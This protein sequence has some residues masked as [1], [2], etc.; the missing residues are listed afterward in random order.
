MHPI[1]P[2]IPQNGINPLAFPQNPNLGRH[3][4]TNISKGVKGIVET[5]KYEVGRLKSHWDEMGRKE[6]FYY[7]T[8]ALCAL[9]AILIILFLTNLF[10]LAAL[11]PAF[12]LG[13]LPWAGGV[14]AAHKAG[15]K[16]QARRPWEM[17]PFS[18]E[19]KGDPEAEKEWKQ[20]WG[21]RNQAKVALNNCNER[22]AKN[23]KMKR[24]FHQEEA[25]YKVLLKKYEDAEV[26]FW[27]F[28]DEDKAYDKMTKYNESRQKRGETE[29]F[30]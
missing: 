26:A 24:D 10:G 18:K 25:Y 14:Y 15:S 11:G 20:L 3:Q 9:I 22:L 29:L 16:T 30:V 4:V 27:R 28:A 13:A 23:K 21:D 12:M 19:V 7:K 5:A 17:P 1:N 8:A 2:G 6:K